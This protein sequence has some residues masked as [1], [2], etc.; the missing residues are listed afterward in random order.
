[1]LNTDTIVHL[2]SD[3][4]MVEVVLNAGKL[5]LSTDNN[6]DDIVNPEKKFPPMTA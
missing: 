4:K 2:T 3:G 5:E 1:M 6:D